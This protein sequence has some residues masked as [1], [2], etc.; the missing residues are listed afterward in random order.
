[1]D[2]DRRK[3][4]GVTRATVAANG[5]NCTI[6]SFARGKRGKFGNALGCGDGRFKLRRF[7]LGVGN[8]LNG[9]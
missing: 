2:L 1:M 8:S 7:S 9:S 3:L 6:G 4:L 5:V